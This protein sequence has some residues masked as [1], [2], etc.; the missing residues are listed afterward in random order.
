MP[1]VLSAV[2]QTAAY[3]ICCVFASFFWTWSD[4]NGFGG[5]SLTVAGYFVFYCVCPLSSLRFYWLSCISLNISL[6]SAWFLC[7]PISNFL[8]EQ[9]SVLEII[10]IFC[11]FFVFGRLYNCGH[12]HSWL[13]AAICIQ[14]K[15]INWFNFSNITKTS[16]NPSV[17]L[18]HMLACRRL[19]RMLYS[20]T[21][22]CLTLC[23][24]VFVGKPCSSHVLN[25]WRVVAMA[26]AQHLSVRWKRRGT[27]D[28]GGRDCAKLHG[29][30]V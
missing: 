27:S 15:K 10:V 21:C 8:P 17:W 24:F 14:Q 30:E 2:L 18:S 19:V 6:C 3:C 5:I 11:S 26:A 16:L 28:G 20:P 23:M 4:S 13:V 22:V 1:S 29:C 25:A 9:S 7:L 12:H